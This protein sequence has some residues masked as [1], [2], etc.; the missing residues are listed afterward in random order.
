MRENELATINAAK[1][2]TVALQAISATSFDISAAQVKPAANTS[3]L[4]IFLL[5]I[6]CFILTS[7]PFWHGQIFQLYY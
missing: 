7:G 5:K 2:S 4:Q 6:R 1:A 3:N